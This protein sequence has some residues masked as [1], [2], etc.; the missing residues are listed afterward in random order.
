M[1]SKDLGLRVRATPAAQESHQRVLVRSTRDLAA[2]EPGWVARSKFLGEQPRVLTLLHTASQST[3]VKTLRGPFSGVPILP[4]RVLA[5][6]AF[7]LM[8]KER[9]ISVFEDSSD[10]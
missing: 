6:K 8:Q 9:G 7:F 10:V 2:V 5:A 4:P 1:L 3:S